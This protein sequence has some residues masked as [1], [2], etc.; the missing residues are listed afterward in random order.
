MLSKIESGK[1]TNKSVKKCL[2]KAPNPKDIELN[3]KLQRLKAFNNNLS[4]VNDSDDD[5]DGGLPPPPSMRPTSTSPTSLSKIVAMLKQEEKPVMSEKL[6]KLLWEADKIFQETSAEIESKNEIPVPNLQNIAELERG[7]FPK[8]LGFFRGSQN[9]KFWK[10]LEIFGL[11]KYMKKSVDYQESE[12]CN[13]LLKRLVILN[14]TKNYKDWKCLTIIFRQI[15]QLL[16][17]LSPL[18]T[19]LST[20]LIWSIK[21]YLNIFSNV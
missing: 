15:I 21:S 11:G 14:W 19:S 10:K 3:Q 12:E 17:F 7:V 2:N 9:A 8:I 5:N 13:E 20:S 4:R 1:L 18:D 16:F 6:N